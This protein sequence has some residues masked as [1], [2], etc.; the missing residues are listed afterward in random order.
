MN[1]GLI[2]LGYWGKNLYRNLLIS[3]QVKKIYVLDTQNK[4]IK[5]DK[6]VSFFL[7]PKVFF[8]NKDIDAFIISTPTSSHYK[9]IKKCLQLDKFVCITKPITTNIDQL[10][11][12][13]KEFKNINKI[14][15]DHTYLFHSSI[16]FI[17]NLVNKKKLG[18]LIYYDSERISFGKFYK[19][20]DVIDDLAIHDLYILDYILKGKIPNKVLVTSHNNFGNKNFLSNISLRYSSGFFA[21][22]K[23]SWYSPIKSRRI[24]LAGDKKIVEFDD[25]ESDRKIKVYN[26]GIK[27]S[28]KNVNQW[29]YRT[30]SIEIPNIAQKESLAVM[31]SEF[32]N[33]ANKKD[34]NLDQFNHAERV[35]KVLKLIKKA[36]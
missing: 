13:K 6:R 27:Y 11:R 16:N 20:V 19:D 17:E 24:L 30:G 1:I 25:N 9:Y 31:L 12:L 28:T 8:K 14:F 33:F 22:I 23:V 4:N 34:N 2:G 35:M 26:K 21:N 15:L 32:I 7:D 3:S 5:K 10:T 29:L 18:K 36:L